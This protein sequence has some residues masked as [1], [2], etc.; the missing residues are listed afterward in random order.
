MR[1]LETKS[2]DATVFQTIGGAFLVSAAQSAFVNVLL[3]TLPFS[4]PDV[5][6]FAVVVTGSTELRQVFTP[7]QVPG[8]LVA[9]MQGLKIAFSLAIGST[10]L[11][12]I[13][14]VFSKWSRLNTAAIT[15]GVA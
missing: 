12:L 3:K 5:N 8:I 7:E 15:G 11:A 6:P 14:V 2:D 1:S 9:Y 10:G 13:I 4:A